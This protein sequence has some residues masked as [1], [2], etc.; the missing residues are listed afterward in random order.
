MIAAPFLY[1]I[2]ILS[3]ILSQIVFSAEGMSV[4]DGHDGPRSIS[5]KREPGNHPDLSQRLAG[6]KKEKREVRNILNINSLP[7]RYETGTRLY[8]QPVPS[9]RV[10]TA[11][12]LPVR[13]GINGS[14]IRKVGSGIN[15]SNILVNHSTINGSTFQ[16]KRKIK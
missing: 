7:L 12:I 6:I 3:T 13:S 15:G 11:Q 1:S 2:L 5:P 16:G 4:R 8:R 14:I 9:G 10:E